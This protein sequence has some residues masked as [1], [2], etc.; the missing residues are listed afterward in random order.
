MV[1]EM[2]VLW[3]LRVRSI[4]WSATVAVVP[5]LFVPPRSI[6]VDPSLS[7]AIVDLVIWLNSNNAI[8]WIDVQSFS[9][10]RRV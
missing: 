2:V 8:P 9:G 10:G 3:P 6:L 5:I 1:N 7:S 4:P